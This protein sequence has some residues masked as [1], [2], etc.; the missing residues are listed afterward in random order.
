MRK[1]HS[2]ILTIIDNEDETDHPFCGKIQPVRN[3]RAVPFHGIDEFHQLVVDLLKAEKKDEEAENEVVR[4]DSR[5]GTIGF[6][7]TTSYPFHPA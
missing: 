3:N 7:S 1:K 6:S 4:P 5:S 2:F